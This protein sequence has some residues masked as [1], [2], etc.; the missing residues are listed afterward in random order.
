MNV[1]PRM[2]EAMKLDALDNGIAYYSD[3]PDYRCAFDDE[4]L[5]DGVDVRGQFRRGK[6][7]GVRAER[8]VRNGEGDDVTTVEHKCGA[9]G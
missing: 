9:D 6:L 3:G 4:I 8:T 5:P 2:R 1:S 7:I